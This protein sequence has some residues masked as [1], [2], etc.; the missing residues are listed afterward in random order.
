M[1]EISINLCSD[2][3]L[4]QIN[5][6]H[7][8]HDYYTDII[9]FELSENN[10]ISGDLYISTDRVLDNAKQLNI[11]F[12]V[13]LNRVIIHG[14]LHLCGYKDKTKAQQKEMREKE[15]YYLSLL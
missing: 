11:T 14:I 8:N 6:K 7:L 3:H 9:T 12:H 10:E 4:L 5:K 13:E 2:D 15:N 1:G